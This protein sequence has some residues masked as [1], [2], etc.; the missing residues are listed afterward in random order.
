M[1][2]KSNYVV[3]TII[4]L[5]VL[6]LF[7]FTGISENAM[8]KSGENINLD[9]ALSQEEEIK[10][11]SKH[12]QIKENLISS[13]ETVEI[14]LV[15]DE[16]KCI[17]IGEEWCINQKKT[18]RYY[19]SLQEAAD[20]SKCAQILIA[21]GKVLEN[22]GVEEAV[23]RLGKKNCSIIF[24]GLPELEKIKE[25]TD[26][27]KCLGIQELRDDALEI[28]GFKLF[29]GFLLGGETVYSEYQQTLPYVK[30][31]ESVEVYAVAQS[32]ESWFLQL[33]NEELPALI[34]RNYNYTG[35][36]YV[37]NADFLEKK[38]GAGILT[39]IAADLSSV[40]IY[41]V[42][43]AQIS[44][45]ENYPVLSKENQ[46][47]MEEKYGRD[48]AAVM[49]DIM[50]PIIAGI[51]YDTNEIMTALFAPQLDYEDEEEADFSL[52]K[53]YY[54]QISKMRGEIGI[55]GVQIG[56]TPLK[57]K[58]EEDEKVLEA[59]LPN[60]EIRTFYAGD[61]EETEYKDLFE[62]GQ[63]LDEIH[64]V[65]KSYSEK[66]DKGLFYYGDE[67]ILN[68]TL[69]IDSSKHS[70][71]DDFMIRCFQT[72]YGYYAAGFD[73]AKIVYPES[74]DDLWNKASENWAKYYRPYRKIF[75]YFDRM[76][77]TEADRK[78]RNYLA[79]DYE[80]DRKEDVMT[81]NVKSEEK[82]NSFLMKTHGERI[83]KIAGG[84]YEELEKGWYLIKTEEAQVTINLEQTDK[85][86]YY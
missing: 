18:Y 13:E 67:N 6:L 2:S 33:K 22:E 83:E 4:M 29:S 84:T 59:E 62:E 68:L 36:V 64:T 38:I 74:E 46:I 40:Y 79:L 81:L 60:Y 57:E 42:V 85:A 56:D 21:D 51:Y 61:L 55:S 7:Q 31:D 66:D 76:T 32:D 49:R 63:V 26:L 50:W 54:Q 65:L 80:T 35:K 19:S 14:G 58:L 15:G 37:V 70:D 23:M 47:V 52:V 48:S 72:A 3:I 39:G 16:E 71:E 86:R 25:N 28:D 8:L 11:K 77:T 5:I 69:Y 34:W 43:N 12:Q 1:V 20:D 73:A 9:L 44:A 53:Y 30:L 45:I 82:Q 78:V 24:S 27:W 75:Q 17:K 10:I 41:P